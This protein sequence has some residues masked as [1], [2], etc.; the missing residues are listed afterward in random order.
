[1]RPQCPKP[2]TLHARQASALRMRA[3]ARR[4][5]WFLS[6]WFFHARSCTSNKYAIFHLF[7]G[8]S[9]GVF[10]YIGVILNVLRV[11]TYVRHV[12]LASQHL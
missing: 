12:R 6:L 3:C 5:A 8:G 10:R 11:D 9:D 7:W 4:V 1:M 2:S